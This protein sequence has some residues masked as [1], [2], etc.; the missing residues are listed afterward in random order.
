MNKIEETLSRF[1][2]E[3]RQILRPV[4]SFLAG[5]HF[6]PNV[7]T[8]GSLALCL[9][10]AGFFSRGWWRP[11]GL[12]LLLSGL[13]DVLDG[14][15]ARAANRTTRFGALFDSV[16]DRYGEFSL[17]FGLGFFFLTR[18][19]FDP[20]HKILIFIVLFAALTGSMMVSYVRARAEGLD[21]ECRVGIMQRSE[22]VVLLGVGALLSVKAVVAVIFLIAV[23]ANFTVFQ[24]MFHV[25]K[26]DRQ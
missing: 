10:A 19:S 24:R 18:W 5:I 13:L 9:L 17:Y 2:S 12:T 14:D 3:S 25:W 23:L 4:V 11:A 21:V 22:R 6:N 20:Q 8:L 15:V 26:I 16:L 1:K 7:I